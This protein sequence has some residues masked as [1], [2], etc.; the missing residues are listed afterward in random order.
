[1]VYFTVLDSV[2][3]SI[4]NSFNES[5]AVLKDL[6]ILSPACLISFGKERSPSIPI[7][8]FKNYA[9]GCQ[10]LILKL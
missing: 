3:S 8:A 1:M 5:K 7:D 10:N 6:S 9:R 2:I 4:S